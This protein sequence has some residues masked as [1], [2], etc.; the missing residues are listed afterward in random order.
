MIFQFAIDLEIEG[1]N[2]QA[3][4]DLDTGMIGFVEKDN[5]DMK[6]YNFLESPLEFKKAFIDRLEDK[7]SKILFS[8]SIICR[9]G[10]AGKLLSEHWNRTKKERQD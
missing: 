1:K 7:T 6:E 5:S 8:N 9:K 10:E 4:I 3:V 2:A